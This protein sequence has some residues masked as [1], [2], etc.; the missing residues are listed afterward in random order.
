MR[1]S[2]WT[3]V[4]ATVVLACP[5]AASAAQIFPSVPPPAGAHTELVSARTVAPDTTRYSYRYGP[6]VAAPGQNLILFGPVTIERPPGDGYITRIRSNFIGEDGKP[7]PVEQ[8][9]LHHAVIANLSQ[10]DATTPRLPQRVYAF[11]EEKTMVTMPAPYGLSLGPSDVWALNYMLHNE[12][13]QNRVVWVTYDLDFVQKASPTGMTM[14]RAFPVDLDVGNGELYPVFDVHQGSGHDGRFTYPDDQPDAY[15][16]GPKLNE[17]TADRDMTLIAA[18][19][20]VHPGGLWVDVNVNRD[21]RDAHLFRSNANY[22]DPNGPVSWDMAMD[23]TPPDWRV[24]IKKGDTLRVSATYDTTRASWYENMGIIGMYA[25]E[26]APGADPFTQKVDLQGAPT[27][28]HLPEDS[29]HGGQ[30]TGRP[31]PAKRPDGQTAPSGVG[32]G[33]FVYMPGDM[34]ESGSLANPPVVARG[35]SLQFANLDASASILHTVTACRQPCTGAT[36]LS[37][38]LADGPVRFD[39]AQLGYGPPGVT[40][41]SERSV[42][43]MPTDLPAGTYTFFCRVHPFMRGSFRVAGT[44]AAGAAGASSKGPP[45]V[46]IVSRSLRMD[47]RGRVPVRLRCNGTGGACRGTLQLAAVRRRKVRALGTARFTVQAGHVRGVRVK[48]RRAPRRLVLRKRRLPVLARARPAAGGATSS[49]TLVLRA[50]SRG[51][52]PRR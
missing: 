40:P 48:F 4:I 31:D 43:S 6:L 24:G 13:P 49:A 35:Q 1:H 39:S 27:H 18:A 30:P 23:F 7:P 29:N 47:R 11:A 16:S 15:G 52:S 46:V 20:H 14:K 33:N 45:R 51:S 50:P 25:T 41:A 32:I 42:W 22:F 10:R 28:G 2:A 19:G 34:A 5:G 12:T 8:V 36:G 17:W 44:P 26:Q 38:P 3:A 37:Y 21:G 9:H